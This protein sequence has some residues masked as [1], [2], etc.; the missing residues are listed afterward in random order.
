MLALWIVSGILLLLLALLLAPV[1]ARAAYVGGGL[2]LSVHYLFL[3]FPIFSMREEKPAKEKPEKEKTPEPEKPG[4]PKKKTK[5][6]AKEALELLK[7]SRGGLNTLRRHLVFYGVEVHA[8][9]GGPDAH[10]AAVFYGKLCAAV[11]CGL[12]VLGGMFVL[13]EPAI[14]IVPAFYREKTEWNIRFRV[15]ILPW[16]VL[17][18]VLRVLFTVLRVFQK[19]GKDNK[20]KGGIPNESA[21]SN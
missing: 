11:L 18:A 8:A 2:S 5:I 13:K 3:R 21:V 4:K 6:G 14:Q 9:V 1:S 19:A 7:G 20:V 16:F 10:Q 15:R 12:S 17:V